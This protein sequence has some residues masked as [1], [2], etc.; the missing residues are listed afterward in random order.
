MSRNLR[1]RTERDL[2]LFEKCRYHAVRLT[3]TGSHRQVF[4]E[5]MRFLLENRKHL[6]TSLKMIGEV[7]T[8]FGDKWHPFLELTEDCLEGLRDNSP[9]RTLADVL[10]VWV[11]Y[12]EAALISAGMKTGN[13]PVAL[14]QADKLINAREQIFGQVVFASVYP[15]VLIVLGGG[16]LGVNNLSL[17]PM[18]SR[19]SDPASWS[20][21]LG[22]MK[23]LSDW[24]EQW[25]P[26]A[27]F[28]GAALVVASLWS[29]P[30]W[31]GRIRRLADS[32]MPWSLY[33]DLQ[34]AVFL[35]NTGALLGA[36]V[37]ELEAMQLLHSFAPPWLQERL[38]AAMDE[39]SE[40]NSL[41]MALRKSGYDFPSREAVNYLSL[42]DD[43]DGAAELISNYADRWL[44]QT[45]R[46]VARRANVTRLLS[47][48][49]I[50]GFFAL[51]IMMVM[52]IQDSGSLNLH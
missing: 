49:L 40:G 21:A 44:T 3:F 9:G 42:L 33:K 15:L 50:M 29:L 48:L 18:L 22:F 27:A 12:E 45:L 51:I 23:G 6:E 8:S 30:R 16:L 32:I 47:M 39:M 28:S 14:M 13:I 26:A 35:M 25:G 20:G 52:Q 10:A 36:G 4:Y 1:F 34:G 5:N 2:S 41:G 11:P 46:R 17:V 19:M 31:R 7:H 24:T 37:H 38:D 43:G